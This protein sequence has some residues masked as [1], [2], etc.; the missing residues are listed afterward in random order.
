MSDG[1]K[2]VSSQMQGLR[3]EIELKNVREGDKVSAQLCEMEIRDWVHKCETGRCEG[4]CTN[5]REEDE[6]VGVQMR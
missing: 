3:L 2:R 5:V 1:E 4:E 6:S